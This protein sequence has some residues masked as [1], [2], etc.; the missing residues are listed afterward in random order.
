VTEGQNIV[1]PQPVNESWVVAPVTFED[2]TKR[3]VIQIFSPT[4]THVSFIPPEHCQSLGEQIIAV[5]RQAQTGLVIPQVNRQRLQ[6]LFRE[7]QQRNGKGGPV[8][9]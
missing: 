3:V 8:E 1:Q 2:G 9:P 7:Q 5:G 6:D 4:G